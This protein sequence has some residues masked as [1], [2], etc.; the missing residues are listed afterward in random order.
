M[1]ERREAVRE[2]RQSAHELLT[3]CVCHM[4]AAAYGETAKEPVPLEMEVL[5]RRIDEKTRPS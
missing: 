3:A 5:L 4:F 1:C 2:M